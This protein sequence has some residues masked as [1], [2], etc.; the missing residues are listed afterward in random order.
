MKGL[1][2]MAGSLLAGL[3]RYQSGNDLLA[4]REPFGDFGH[5]AAGS[6]AYTRRGRSVV[7][8]FTHSS[9]LPGAA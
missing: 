7:P 8:S 3:G 6:A 5:V 1:R 9:L 4:A 2:S